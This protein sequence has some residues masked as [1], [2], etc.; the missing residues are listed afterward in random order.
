[1]RPRHI[2]GQVH[3]RVTTCFVRR[4]ARTPR[5][6]PVD[7]QWT[8]DRAVNPRPVEPHAAASRRGVVPV[9]PRTRAPDRPVRTPRN[10]TRS[11][12]TK[13]HCTLRESARRCRPPRRATR[14][15]RVRGSVARC[16]GGAG[17]PRAARRRS[18]SVVGIRPV[19][20]RSRRTN[21]TCIRNAFFSRS[22][23]PPPRHARRRVSLSHSCARAERPCDRRGVGGPEAED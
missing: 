19:Q 17:D 5:S 16:R 22:H 8:S 2:G 13:R 18:R 23:A 6:T 14:R 9:E 21:D 20:R 3:L 10:A 4:G 15:M 7:Q 1:M 12:K 11:F